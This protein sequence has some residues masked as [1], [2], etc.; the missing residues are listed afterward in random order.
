[1][2]L[3]VGVESVGALGVTPGIDVTDGDEYAPVPIVLTA[4]IL[5]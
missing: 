3:G 1:V 5:K 4:A 2:L